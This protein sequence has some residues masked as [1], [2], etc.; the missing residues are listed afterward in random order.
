M[1]EEFPQ[2]GHGNLLGSPG[3]FS[4]AAAFADIVEFCLVDAL[5]IFRVPVEKIPDDA[6]ADSYKTSDVED[7]PPTKGVED[8]KQDR[9]QKGQSHKFSSRIDRRCRCPFAVRKPGG[10]DAAVRGKGR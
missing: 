8:P 4:L 9:C 3:I 7:F 5:T 10:N 6:D 2:L 1:T